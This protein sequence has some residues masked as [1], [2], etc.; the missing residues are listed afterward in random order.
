MGASRDPLQLLCCVWWMFNIAE[1]GMVEPGLEECGKFQGISLLV[2]S[3]YSSLLSLWRKAASE[4]RTVPLPLKPAWLIKSLQNPVQNQANV[5]RLNPTDIISKNS[6]DFRGLRLLVQGWNSTKPIENM[7]FFDAVLHFVY[8]QTTQ[9]KCL[10]SPWKSWQN[11]CDMKWCGLLHH[12]HPMV[13]FF[14]LMT[15]F[16]SYGTCKQCC[17]RKEW[18]EFAKSLFCAPSSQMGKEI[19][20]A[21]RMHQ[22]SFENQDLRVPSSESVSLLSF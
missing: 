16:S 12:P 15:S 21:R 8:K 13:P 22:N 6:V 11:S 7:S 10:S 20:S 17:S 18:K 3:L 1:K 19:T 4:G 14:S 2:S 5:D 9:V